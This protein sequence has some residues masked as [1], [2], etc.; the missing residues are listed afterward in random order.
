[1]NI[2]PDPEK[3]GVPLNPKATGE[4]YLADSVALWLADLRKWAIVGSSKL[5][6]PESLANQSWAKYIGPCPT[7]IE[8]DALR[9]KS[10]RLR[11]ALER[12]EAA[13]EGM[14]S[15]QLTA[16]E[17]ANLWNATMES[18]RAALEEKP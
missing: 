9:A 11:E 7:F 5:H 2:W 18:I 15:D 14:A 10:K 4:H 3:P 13:M 16:V 12:A 6:T 17:T 8:V 1:M